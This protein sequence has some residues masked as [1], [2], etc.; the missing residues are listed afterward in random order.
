MIAIISSDKV[1][2][3]LV[4]GAS[5]LVGILVVL[6]SRPRRWPA[7]WALISLAAIAVTVLGAW[8]A[9]RAGPPSTEAAPAAGAP[10]GSPPPAMGGPGPGA[11]CSPNGTKLQLAAQGI[12]FDTKCLAAPAETGFTIA[13]DNKDAGTP[14]NVHIFAEDPGKDPNAKSLFAGDL[15]T[16]PNST[17]YRV[18][19]LPKGTYFFHCDVHPTQMFG[20]FIAG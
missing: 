9:F 14:H 20:T 7:L 4:A 10:A 8:A 5:L 15:V 13:F 18:S 17:T 19:A 12:A 16:G 11:R 6:W 2:F 1:V 3:G